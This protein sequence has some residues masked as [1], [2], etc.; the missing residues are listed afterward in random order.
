MPKTRRRPRVAYQRRLSNSFDLLEDRRLLSVSPI[1]SWNDESTFALSRRSTL[2]GS[3]GNDELSF[4]ASQ[5]FVVASATFDP[6]ISPITPFENNTSTGEKPQSKV[7]TH[8]NRWFSVMTDDTG[9]HVFRL[10]SLAWTK[11]FTLSSS[12]NFK[13]DVTPDGDV[14]HIL[15]YNGTASKLASIQY[16][17]ADDTWEFW[18]ERPSLTN[19]TLSTG[20]E[21]ATMDID[22]TGR[23]WVVSDANTTIEA[24]WADAPYTSFSATPIIVATG[25]TSDDISDVVAL[26]NNTIGVLWS[27]QTTERFGFK[28]HVD[29]AAPTTWSADEAPAA[30]VAEDVGSG[31]ADDHIQMVVASDSTL[32]ATIKTGYNSNAHVTV[33]LLVRRPNGTWDNAIYEVTAGTGTRPIV[34]LSEVQ[35]RVIVA[36][37]KTDS[38]GPIVYKDSSTSTIAFGPEHTLIDAVEVND[39]SSTKQNFTSE[40][41]FIASGTDPVTGPLDVDTAVSYLTA[42]SPLTPPAGDHALPVATPSC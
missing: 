30:G 24:R 2:A 20:V 15:L 8:D 25:I 31:F 29:G 7:W 3:L 13:A 18:S 5:D 41:V 1:S 10:D 35:S 12:G 38:D 39:V 11:V 34:V 14:A 21:V 42:N 17:P 37:R 32:Y 27:N 16:R 4:S 9:T 6:V 22:T 40:V 23:M 36:Y 19:I 26:P 33:G 28:V